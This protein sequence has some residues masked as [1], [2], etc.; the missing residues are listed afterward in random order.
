MSQ[1]DIQASV[2]RTLALLTLAIQA[3]LRAQ[4]NVAVALERH[5]DRVEAS[6]P[7]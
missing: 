4:Q 3:A 6:K 2:E 7:R 5:K 1:E